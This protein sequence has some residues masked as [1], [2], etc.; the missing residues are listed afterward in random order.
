MSRGK[1]SKGA[2]GVTACAFSGDNQMVGA[3]DLSNDHC[4]YVFNTSD[5]SLKG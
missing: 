5:M 4:V 1:L 3:V 2:R